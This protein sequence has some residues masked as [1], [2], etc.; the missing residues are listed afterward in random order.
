[1]KKDLLSQFGEKFSEVAKTMRESS[2]KT[3]EVFTELMDFYLK[4]KIYNVLKYYSHAAEAA[5]R[6][7][8]RDYAKT[9]IKIMCDITPFRNFD[10][11]SRD[12]LTI[13]SYLLPIEETKEYIDLRL[14]SDAGLLD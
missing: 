3:E 2:N 14:K 9:V 7:V 13:E 4:N 11:F 1:M 6:P 5:N 8:E 12:I 10:K